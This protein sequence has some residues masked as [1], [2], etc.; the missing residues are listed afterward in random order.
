MLLI[1]TRSDTF[2]RTVPVRF[3]QPG[4][5]FREGEFKA[6]FKRVDKPRLDEMLEA[7]NGYTQSD[8]LDEVLVGVSGIGRSASEELPPDEQLAWVKRSPECCAAAF[9][10]FFAAMRQEPGAGKTSKK[11]R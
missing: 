6:T 7:E 2:E 3:A 11:P 10:S 4:G 9:N 1:E 5:T 8:V